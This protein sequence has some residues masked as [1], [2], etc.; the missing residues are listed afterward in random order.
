MPD[1]AALR[2]QTPAPRTY[3][4]IEVLVAL[5]ILLT[6]AGM[7]VPYTERVGQRTA[8]ATAASDLEAIA[9]NLASA[10]VARTSWLH[11]PGELPAGSP[12]EVSAHSA[13]LDRLTAPS[14]LSLQQRAALLVALR[15]DPWGSAYLIHLIAPNWEARA[16]EVVCAGPDR[17]FRTSDDL[18]QLIH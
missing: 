4:L 18:Q 11:G 2:P 13:S 8:L 7:L 3:R 5:S 10:A 6:L 15:P 1:F 12:E 17:T 14:S 16:S 9:S